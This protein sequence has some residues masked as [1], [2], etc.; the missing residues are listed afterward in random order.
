MAE[1]SEHFIRV[2]VER[3]MIET[4]LVGQLQLDARIDLVLECRLLPLRWPVVDAQTP[5]G[6]VHEGPVAYV[7]RLGAF[8]LVE[9][10]SLVVV[11]NQV[12]ATTFEDGESRL[13]WLTFS[14][15]QA[16][17]RTMLAEHP[18][19]RTHWE[20]AALWEFETGNP[21]GAMHPRRELP[22]L[23]GL[24]AHPGS[25]FAVDLLTSG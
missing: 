7:G 6:L 13:H 25:L 15:Y 4:G 17:L 19:A 20:V 10:E 12:D 22:G 16:R 8:T 21:G 2:E 23:E 5:L 11:L 1:K 9:V 18:T 24:M 3:W 14:P